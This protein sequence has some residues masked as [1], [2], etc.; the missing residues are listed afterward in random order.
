MSDTCHTHSK[1]CTVARVV[2]LSHSATCHLRRIKIGSWWVR[3]CACFIESGVR[4]FLD[5]KLHLNRCH[6][7]QIRSRKKLSKIKNSSQA[8]CQAKFLTSRHVLMYRVMRKQIIKASRGAAR[9]FL[10]GGLKLWKQK[11]WKGKIACDKNSQESAY[12]VDK[13]LTVLTM[14]PGVLP[15]KLPS[16]F[17]DILSWR[18]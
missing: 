11:L 2:P 10:R 18:P 4:N 13:Q 12:I 5:W 14:K 16:C 17:S 9:I 15:T 3:G 8:R 7:R 6:P 1:H